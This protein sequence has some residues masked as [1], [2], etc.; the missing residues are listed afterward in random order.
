M[1]TTLHFS[2]RDGQL[3]RAQGHPPHPDRFSR[4][5]IDI[6]T[7]LSETAAYADGQQRS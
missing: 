7:M 4:V 5:G 3:V 2:T 1:G 6:A